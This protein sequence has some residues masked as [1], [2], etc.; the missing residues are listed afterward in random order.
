MKDIVSYCVKCIILTAAVLVLLIHTH[1]YQV[2][3]YGESQSIISYV[4]G[5]LYLLGFLS[6]FT[7]V[8]YLKSRNHK[9]K[10]PID[11]LVYNVSDMFYTATTKMTSCSITRHIK[12]GFIYVNPNKPAK[13]IGTFDGSFY[14]GALYIPSYTFIDYIYPSY[15]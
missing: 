6:A 4:Y 8:V 1:L 5:I 13:F 7:I 14:I 12:C 2:S 15:E 11:S 9:V 3:H 10:F